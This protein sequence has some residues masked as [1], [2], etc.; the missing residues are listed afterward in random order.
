MELLIVTGKSGAGK[1]LSLDILE[2]LNYYCIDNLPPQIILNFT[3]F[4]SEHDTMQRK[5]AFGIDSRS[6]NMF[7][8]FENVLSDLEERGLDYK[9]LYLDCSP[10]VLQRRYKESRRIHPL[11]VTE[12]LSFESAI[13]REELYLTPIRS[14][15]S[16][17][18]DTSYLKPAQLRAKLLKLLSVDSR[19][20]MLINIYSFGF[21]HGPVTDADL[22]FD[23]RCLP[24]PFYI[25]ELRSL[26]GNDHEVNQ[27]VMGFTEATGMLERILDFL[28]FTIPL[29]IAEGKSQLVIGLGCTGGKHRSVTFANYLADDL[30][31]KGYKI[32][33]THRDIDK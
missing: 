3:D 33:L 2:D 17:I 24:N 11:M 20:S 29:Y 19:D 6:Q 14:R 7:A 10:A 22:V 32:I 9:I 13:K 27:Y 16:Y 30:Q 28:D 8:D 4:M 23:L 15:A 21:K 25:E 18:I 31:S 12:N 5:I 26:T 1:S